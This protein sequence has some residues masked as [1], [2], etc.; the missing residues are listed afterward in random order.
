MQYQTLESLP[1]A[2]EAYIYRLNSAGEGRRRLLDL[3]FSVG[4]PVT[5]LFRSPFGSLTAYRIMGSIIALRPEDASQILI[6]PP[7]REALL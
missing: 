3:G 1:L 7:K 4:R 5:A 2:R 6:C